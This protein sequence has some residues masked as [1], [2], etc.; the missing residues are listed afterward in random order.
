MCLNQE[1][2]TK[3]NR[4]LLQISCMTLLTLLEKK[5]N[6]VNADYTQK[7]QALQAEWDTQCQHLKEFA[8][9]LQGYIDGGQDFK[10]SDIHGRQEAAY[11]QV[12]DLASKDDK[13][14]MY[15]IVKEAKKQVVV[16]EVKEQGTKIDS[17]VMIRGVEEVKVI[18][19]ALNGR[20]FR[21]ELKYRGSRDGFS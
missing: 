4:E 11:E 3:A 14:K 15:F 17:T 10:A 20:R 18:E 12:K 19:E 16:E 6:K 2:F 8:S 7:I 9:V 13:E 1:S 21:L 5:N